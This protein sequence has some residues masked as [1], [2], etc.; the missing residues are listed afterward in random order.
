M[1]HLASEKD[2]SLI[3]IL[4]FTDCNVDY[5][6]CQLAFSNSNYNNNILCD[7]CLCLY[8]NWSI[9]A[10]EIQLIDWLIIIYVYYIGNTVGYIYYDTYYLGLFVYNGCLVKQYAV[11]HM[12][13]RQPTYLVL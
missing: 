13:L 7:L 2:N 10:D 8:I 1:C 6:I 3:P 5:R 9:Q 12:S 11:S 4:T